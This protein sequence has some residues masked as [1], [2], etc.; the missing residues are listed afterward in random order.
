MYKIIVVD[1]EPLIRKWIYENINWN[2]NGFVFSGDCEDGNEAIELIEEIHPDV[3]LTDICMPFLDGL[4]LSN[5]V[6]QRFPDTKIILLTG[7]DN[8]DYA[9]KAVKLNVYDYILKPITIEDLKKILSRVKNDLEKERNSTKTIVELKQ[10]LSESL[11]LLRERFLN[12][13]LNGK[14]K[15]EEIKNRLSYLGI[16]FKYEYLAIIGISIDYSIE[17]IK[18]HGEEKYELFLIAITNLC[19]EI[20]KKYNLNGEIFFDNNDNIVII[21][22]SINEENL[23]RQK[24]EVAEKIRQQ[25]EQTMD[26]TVTI[27]IGTVIKSITRLAES[28]NIAILSLGYR[29]LLGINQ[30][31]LYKHLVSGK[32]VQSILKKDWAHEVYYSL[33]ICNKDETNLLIKNIFKNIKSEYVPMGKCIVFLQKILASIFSIIDELDFNESELFENIK[34]PFSYL[35]SFK[36]LD[37]LEKWLVHVCEKI[38]ILMEKRQDSI[39]RKKVEDAKK[40]MLDNYNQEDINLNSICSYLAVSTSKFS[41][42]LKK[43][44]GQTFIEYLTRIRIDKSMELL[45]ST[46]NKIYEIAF[47]AGFNDPHYFSF[48]FRRINGIT[49]NQ[50]REKIKKNNYE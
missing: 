49:P 5:Y 7:Y 8:F 22:N 44:S 24:I 40:Y 15:E 21:L 13:I 31:I 23:S 34:N 11:P 9:Q 46:D 32:K 1:D 30:I 35:S 33:K 27:G 2:E 48:I 39:N 38:N 12:K 14:I 41:Q 6:M 47:K 42:I 29:F 37:N 50:Y 36:T 17:I 45:K 4:E 43:Y 19:T 3:I 25:I 10:K 20:L 26:C 18:N 16:I 28:Y